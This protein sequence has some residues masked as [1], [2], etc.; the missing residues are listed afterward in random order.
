[1]GRDYWPFVL[2]CVLGFLNLPLTTATPC[3]G[4]TAT[5]EKKLLTSEGYPIKYE[6]SQTCSWSLQASNA[7]K[8]VILE[9]VDMMI[10]PSTG[11]VDDSVSI[12]DGDSNSSTRLHTLCRDTRVFVTSSGRNMYLEFRSNSILETRGFQF[13]YYQGDKARPC[14]FTF[15]ATR[16]VKTFNSPGYPIAYF[17][18]LSCEYS[19]QAADASY[20]LQLEFTD[21][22]VQSSQ[23]CR[24]DNISV[25]NIISGGDDPVATICGMPTSS[26][27]GGNNM[28]V[29]FTSD[30]S[31]VN[32]GFSVG[33]RSVPKEECSIHVE[34]T[35]MDSFIMSPGYPNQYFSNMNCR[36]TIV[37][38]DNDATVELVAVISDIADTSPSCSSDRV[39][40]TD[41][42][43]TELGIFCGTNKPTYNSTGPNVTVVFTTDGTNQATGFRLK[44][45]QKRATLSTCGGALTASGPEELLSPGYPRAYLRSQTCIWT[46]TAYNESFVNLK[47]VDIDVEVSD[48]CQ[49]DSLKIYDGDSSASPLLGTWCGQMN[50]Y[51]LQSTGNVM[52]LV[53]NTDDSNNGRG[54]NVRYTQE[55]TSMVCDQRFE[56]TDT[57]S[58]ITSPNYPNSFPGVSG[59]SSYKIECGFDTRNKLEVLELNLPER[60][61]GECT[62]D[63]ITVHDGWYNTSIPLKSINTQNFRFCG[64]ELP[65]FVS[66]RFFMF[67][68]FH[69]TQAT[70]TSSFR[71]RYLEG[72]FADEYVSPCGGSLIATDGV[73]NITSP[74][75][76]NNYTG[77]VNCTWTIT[78]TDSTKMVRLFSTDFQLLKRPF[79]YPNCDVSIH[80]LR[81]YDGGYD[82]NY[83]AECHKQA[84]MQHQSTQN[85]MTVVLK[86]FAHTNA[87]RLQYTQTADLLSCDHVKDIGDYGSIKFPGSVE[88]PVQGRSCSWLLRRTSMEDD[89]YL[90]LTINSTAL[91]QSP[92]CTK[93]YIR[94][95]DGQSSSSPLIGRFCGGKVSEL[96]IFGNNV[97]ITS[98]MSGQGFFDIDYSS[99]LT[100]LLDETKYLYPDRKSILTS[101]NYPLNY[102]RNAEFS[103]TL[104]TY[105]EKVVVE[106]M[107]S[108]IE[109]SEG[110]VND[111]AEAYD[112]ASKKDKLLGKWCGTET[113]SFES[114]G[115][116]LTIVLFSNDNEIAG[117]GFKIKYYNE[118]ESDRGYIIGG[119]V[120]G[121]LV[122]LVIGA[123]VFICVKRPC[124]S[125]HNMVQ[126]KYVYKH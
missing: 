34:A 112:G 1:M 36:W 88:G 5:T 98:A 73:Q 109:M 80:Y 94:V 68:Q 63:Y 44:Y 124:K 67:V 28:K 41:S 103:W 90:K 53:F 6:P 115:E 48:R 113:P 116:S 25:A 96:S 49:P 83:V 4:L 52:T 22:D 9:T 105:V 107:S 16:D 39:S 24:D 62:S 111:R 57:Y 20:S 19:I 118:K 93:D 75:Y 123:A 54:F 70:T 102:P 77:F 97:F 59:C 69:S 56:A 18:G 85:K 86:A 33:Y 21:V 84:L 61:S 122:I 30:G 32:K 40:V 27:Q 12:Y 82:S 2:T 29:T 92:N 17:N 64:K 91:I 108:Q 43:M 106:V 119:V 79:P 110:C 76:P 99:G 8:N 126:A 89:R 120:G 58:Y 125:R 10:Q 104:T 13:R 100:V 45:K 42:D 66:P 72:I 23:T 3:G 95:Y 14:T 51:R 121:V 65:T 35:D 47:L 60:V 101:P 38:T 87:F 46:I 81:I 31:K 78:A 114:S 11:C 26:Y 74:N 15:T 37:A 117:K 71:M 50:G 7:T 55:S